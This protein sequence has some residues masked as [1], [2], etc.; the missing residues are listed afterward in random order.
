MFVTTKLA[1]AAATG[2]LSL[3]VTGA[4]AF[5]AFQPDAVQT[6]VSGTDTGAITASAEREGARDKVKDVLDGL[7]QKGV[8]TQ[9]Q[10]TKILEAFKAAHDGDHDRDGKG[11]KLA[12]GDLMKISAD[13]LGLSGAD[14]KAKLQSGMSL[15]EIANAI[16]GQ[17]SRDGLITF[18]VAKV[19]EQID[20]LVA[21]GKITADRAKDIKSR[22]QEHVTKFVD[23]KFDGK[24]ADAKGHAKTDKK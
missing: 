10:E 17:H 3:A 13:Y 20:K 6:V 19:S 24:R 9:D 2:V 22:L 4:A 21:D 18:D 7:V 16:G 14:L 1:T 8:I 23:H 5:A 15:G 12:L 11:L